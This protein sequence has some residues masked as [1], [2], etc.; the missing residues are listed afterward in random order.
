[1]NLFGKKQV[2]DLVFVDKTSINHQNINEYA[3][4]EKGINVVEERCRAAYK[5]TPV[6]ARILRGNHGTV[7]L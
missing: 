2:E 4:S 6:T 3:A 1:M 5:K 7:L